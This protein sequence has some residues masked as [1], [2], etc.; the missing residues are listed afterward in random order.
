M[1][2]D[3]FQVS[4]PQSGSAERLNAL[5]SLRF[6]AALHVLLFHLQ[7]LRAWPVPHPVKRIFDTGF[8]SV[9]FF[10][11]LS[12][13]ILT[14]SYANR[15]PASNVRR[16]LM[17]R[18]ARI[19]PV[20]LFALFISLPGWWAARGGEDFVAPTIATL[21][22]VQSWV[23]TWA[24]F[25]NPPAWSLSVEALFYLV[26]PLLL[27][28]LLRRRIREVWSIAVVG[29]AFGLALALAYHVLQPDGLSVVD[30]TSPGWWL[31][32]LRY[33]P[34]VRLPE[35]VVG[36]ALARTML[37]RPVNSGLLQ[38]L[39]QVSGLV[40]I[41][42]LGYSDS[43]P[44]PVLHNGILTPLF[45]ILIAGAATLP[46]VNALT[47]RWLQVCGEASY[48]LYIL[49]AGVIGYVSAVVR[50][51]PSLSDVA[52]LALGAVTLVLCVIVSIIS[53]R[54]IERPARGWILR[55]FDRRD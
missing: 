49:Q 36:M 26:F 41:V 19:Y 21:L 44:Y 13:F 10:F 14:W 8:V 32:G 54:L 39:A 20:Y 34:L 24:T 53:W 28:W 33:H 16:Y 31:D 48:S 37:D 43:I 9:S 7:G 45:V 15:P 29:W 2:G 40:L 22:L 51:V 35:F 18:I 4:T 47:H 52:P 6:V 27:P 12:G 55:T 30:H 25:W 38:R 17:S 11:V 3:S 1:D 46:P 42:V 23:P 5:T 50:R